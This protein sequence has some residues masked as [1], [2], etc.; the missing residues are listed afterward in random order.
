MLEGSSKKVVI[1]NLFIFAV[2]LGLLFSWPQYI[3]PSSGRASWFCFSKESF[4]NS[5]SKW[6]SWDKSTLDV[7]METI[8]KLFQSDCFSLEF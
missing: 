7:R 4:P 8:H 3:L 5:Y 2:I 6:F 1:K